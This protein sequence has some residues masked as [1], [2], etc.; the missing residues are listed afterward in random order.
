MR[1]AERNHGRTQAGR[2]LHAALVAIG[3]LVDVSG[4]ATYVQVRR[5]MPASRTRINR[6]VSAR[7]A[8][9]HDWHVLGH[10][11]DRA[12]ARARSQHPAP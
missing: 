6:R 4:T 9:T 11:F 7:D 8:P 12:T 10:D 2:R 1:I 3:S 5:L